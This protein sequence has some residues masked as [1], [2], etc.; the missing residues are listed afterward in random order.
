MDVRD[1]KQRGYQLKHGEIDPRQHNPAEGEMAA[2][3]EKKRRMKRKAKSDDVF[4]SVQLSN[5]FPWRHVEHGTGAKKLL[6]GYQWTNVEDIPGAKR[7]R[8]TTA[9]IPSLKRP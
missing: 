7:T 4:M 9:F 8:S 1:A 3:E 2:K 5:E 6:V